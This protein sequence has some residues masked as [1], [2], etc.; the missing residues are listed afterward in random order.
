MLKI[1]KIITILGIF[2]MSSCISTANY[3]EFKEYLE[4]DSQLST[5]YYIMNYRSINK[6][7]T[8][9]ELFLIRQLFL[10]DIVLSINNIQLVNNEQIDKIDEFNRLNTL[11]IS[12]EKLLKGSKVLIKAEP[13]YQITVKVLNETLDDY[14]KNVDLITIMKKYN[15]LHKANKKKLDKNVDY[16]L[17]N[18][19]S[20]DS[21]IK[22]LISL[23]DEEIYNLNNH[24]SFIS[25]NNTI[26]KRDSK[27]EIKTI[28]KIDF[29]INNIDETL[30]MKQEEMINSE[31]IVEYKNIK[32]IDF[33]NIETNITLSKFHIE[34]YNKEILLLN[35]TQE[36]VQDDGTIIIAI[37]EENINSVIKI[38]KLIKKETRRI[39][40]L[41]NKKLKTDEFIIKPIIGQYAYLKVIN[42]KELNIDLNISL[43]N[44][45]KKID[46]K[47]INVILNKDFI[48]YSGLDLS[49]TS[50]NEILEEKIS[51]IYIEDILES[52]DNNIKG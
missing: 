23:D 37:P 31:R 21:F 33:Q 9:S 30:I 49:D 8:E 26:N 28:I 48:E 20:V 32:N 43:I 25:S 29:D 22:I 10:D 52:F 12:Y 6:Y 38:E 44:S 19:R 3:N 45:S 41:L 42:K 4:Y 36:I 51:N 11:T 13:L 46:S 7:I 39:E 2:I 18:I 16:Y 15:I 47:S 34:N 5:D 24:I 1:I 35:I 40:S 27:N 50:Y 14:Y 17:S